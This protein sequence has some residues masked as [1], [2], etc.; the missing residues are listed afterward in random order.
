MS[1]NENVYKVG[2][3]IT[4]VDLN[5]QTKDFSCSIEAYCE[6]GRNFLYTIYSQSQ[7]DNQPLANKLTNKL[8]TTFTS[9]NKKF[10]NYYLV[11][12][13]PDDMPI[14]VR[15]KTLI[16]RLPP[17]RETKKT[18]NKSE[19]E[20]KKNFFKERLANNSNHPRDSNEEGIITSRVVFN[21]LLAVTAFLTIVYIAKQK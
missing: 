17:K 8:R 15:V 7:L 3:N 11:L 9:Y 14:N 16:T 4:L 18:L 2:K 21:S 1:V 20:G 5:E 12:Q 19:E 10:E 13:C 6:E